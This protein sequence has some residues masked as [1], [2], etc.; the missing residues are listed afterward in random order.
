VA[1]LRD[2]QRE[3]IDVFECLVAA[4]ARSVLV[5]APTGSGKT[6]IVSATVARTVAAG[7]RGLMFGNRH[8]IID[9]TVRKLCDDRQW[10]GMSAGAICEAR[11]PLAD[12]VWALGGDRLPTALAIVRGRQ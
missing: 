5:T 2:Y 1:K 4:G 8:Q 7:Q 9:P 3:T 10:D 6:V 12:S 11:A